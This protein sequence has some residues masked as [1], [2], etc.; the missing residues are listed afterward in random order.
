M[1]KMYKFQRMRKLQEEGKNFSEIA[2][3][4][5]INRKTV[6]KYLQSNTPP[7]YKKRSIVSRTDPLV[8][9]AGRLSELAEDDENLAVDI[10][11]TLV[12]EGYK[13]SDRT[14]RRRVA[15]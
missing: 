12:E 6:A 9:F 3:D 14:V 15:E 1:V 5:K 2:R 11:E 13:G 8:P 4:L 7:K 10:Y